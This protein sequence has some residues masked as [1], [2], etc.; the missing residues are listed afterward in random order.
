MNM[1]ERIYYLLDELFAYL[2]KKYP[3]KKSYKVTPEYIVD[4]YK[5]ARLPEKRN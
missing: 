5:K 3:Y 4:S 1:C 2:E